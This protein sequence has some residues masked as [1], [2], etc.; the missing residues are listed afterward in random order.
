[1]PKQINVKLGFTA[2]TS[3]AKKQLEDLRKSLQDLTDL[4]IKRGSGKE[5]FDKQFNDALIAVQKLDKALENSTNNTT[6][7][8]DLSKLNANLYEYGESISSLQVKMSSLGTEGNEAF[9]KVANSIMLAQKPMKE[10][11]Q[12]LD[13]F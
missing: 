5:G 10:T 13:K 2:D 7:M 11:N 1:M 6:G 8:L 4:S 12:L 9:L 3:Q